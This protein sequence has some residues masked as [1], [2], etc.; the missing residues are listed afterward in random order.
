L[1]G[2]LLSLLSAAAFAFNNVSARRGVLT[3]SVSQG[4]SISTPIGVPILVVI[5][6]VFGQLGTVATFTPAAVAWLSAA[7][8][9]H[10]VIG[11]YFN[12]RG[13]KAMGGNLSGQLQQISILIS[14]SLAIIFLGEF[15]TPIKVLGIALLFF[16]LWLA[17]RSREARLTAQS[18]TFTPDMAGGAVFSLLA[19]VCYGL[20]P[21]CVRMGLADTSIGTAIAGSLVSYTAAGAAALLTLLWPGQFRHAIAIDRG[22]ARWFVVAGVFVCLSQ[23]LR[24]MALALAP[25]TVVAPIQQTSVVFRIIFAW[26]V[27]R[28][29]EVFDLQVVIGI[30]ISLVGTVG[31]ALGADFI[32]EYLPLPPAVVEFAQWQWP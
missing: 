9:I 21:L 25:V 23:M 1:L 26:F 29:H 8:I 31:I 18:K 7:G 15:M 24:Y 13:V 20:S 2:G 12:Y 16:G 30:L 11:R 6:L 3:G 5:A 10:F 28:E 4:I 22:A 27:N 17:L 19:G 14:L 32:F